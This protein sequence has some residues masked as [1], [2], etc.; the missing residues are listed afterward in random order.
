[1]TQ[2]N[3]EQYQAVRHK[4]GPMLVLAGPGSGKTAVIVG[5]VLHLIKEEH[6]NPHGILV[7]TFSRLA[8]AQMQ[9]RFLE[10]VDEP[11]PVTFGTFHAIFYHILKRQGLYRSGEIL[12]N[13]RKLEILRRVSKRT[14]TGHCDDLPALLR[15]LNGI[16]SRKMGNEEFLEDFSDD[17]RACLDKV[18]TPYIRQ[19]REEGALDFDDMI[20]EC[21]KALK[22]NDKIL[23]KWQERYRYILVDEFQDIDIRQYE[24]LKLLAGEDKNV[25]C[26][27][28]DDQSI[29]SFRGARPGIIKGMPED[30]QGTQIVRLKLNYRCPDK[31]IEH[32]Y[33]LITKNHSRFDKP[34][35][36]VNGEGEEC[37]RYR[38]FKTADEEAEFCVRLIDELIHDEKGKTASVAVLYRISK[39]ADII[40]ERLRNER[41]LYR[42]KDMGERF[43]DKEWVMDI[44]AYL[45]YAVLGEK[46]ELTRLLNRPYRGLS[47]ECL[48]G[49][50]DVESILGFYEGDE[51]SKS[52]IEKLFKDIGFIRE[53]NCYGAVNYIL[54]GIGMHDFIKERYFRGHSDELEEALTEISERAR[55]F[56][57]IKEWI[58]AI[59]AGQDDTDTEY[60][61]GEDVMVQ[62]MTIHGSKGLEFDNVIMI[63]LQEGVFPGKR[64]ETREA[65]EEERRLFYVAMTRC[66]KRLWL[67]GRH[68]DDYGKRESRFLSEAGFKSEIL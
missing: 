28:D 12:T 58:T 13:N 17:E 25:F 9:L 46:N 20:N 34:Q 39:S 67:L 16:S 21:L 7:L 32:A 55:G 36:C 45:R 48:A 49:T 35:E 64:C 4:D 2:F 59:D 65:L 22:G 6:V 38:C 15:I 31:V 44:L 30:F 26:V 43:Y 10:A 61:D 50:G 54:K 24:I 27:G 52:L 56:K 42:R 19:C 60:I 66:R 3:K 29:Y 1:M 62:L 63:G 47:R 37:V 53:L 14:G 18:F 23:K 33:S 41:I 57:S 5:R 68:K 51:E 8:A 40:E 11:Y